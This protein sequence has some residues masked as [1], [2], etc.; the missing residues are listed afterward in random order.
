MHDSKN[1]NHKIS[2]I[3]PIFKEPKIHDNLKII[4]ETIAQSFLKYEIICVEDGQDGESYFKNTAHLS[5][6]VKVLSY[7]MN[8]GKGFAFLYGFS[9]SSGDIVALLDGDLDIHPRYVCLAADLMDLSDADIVVGSKRHPL[10]KITYPPIRKIY[11]YILQ[12]LV[13]LLFGLN[14]SD[15]QVGMK[16]FKR[17]VLEKVVPK[18][19][20]K[21]WAFDLEIL[22]VAYYFGFR[23]IIDTPI[24]LKMSLG[25]KVNLFTAFKF[26]QD[27][28]A[29]FYRRYIIRYYDRKIPDS[30]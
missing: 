21:T 16:L 6:H 30:K 11:S 1:N 29:I 4:E 13:R 3:V 9:Q 20:V 5:D 2:V 22:V 18:L 24:N 19:V 10:S 25:S 14:I 23:K 8:V 17:S 12:L 26:L 15:T 28:A 7:P 27:M